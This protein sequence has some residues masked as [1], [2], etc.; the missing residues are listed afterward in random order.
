MTPLED[1]PCDVI[2]KA[3]T[4]HGLTPQTMAEK[5]GITRQQAQSA[6]DGDHSTTVLEKLATAL[7]LS[8][9]ALVGL[10]NYR[11]EVSPPAGLHR[12]VTPFGHAGV[13]SYVITA[14]THALVF[15]TGTDSQPVTNF[16][17]ANGLATEAV[18]I[19]HRHNDH[20]AGAGGFSNTRIIYPEDCRHGETRTHQAHKPLRVLDVRGHHPTAK[21]YFYDGLAIPV[22][23]TGDSVFAGSMGKTP[24]PS[25]YQTALQTARENLM[26]LPANTIL[27]PGHGPLTTVQNELKHNPFLA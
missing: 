22:C 14:G 3:M 1:D 10:T 27:C 11:P 9:R 16:L 25:S 8:P 13:N 20:T 5:A 6:L 15:D 12:F 18:Y 23:I 7:H 4:G 19:T 2:R 21:A 17:H 24:D 26:S